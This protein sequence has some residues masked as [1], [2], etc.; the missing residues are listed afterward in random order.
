[1]PG[2]CILSASAQVADYLRGGI[3]AGRW[4]GMMPGGH[5]LAIELGVG[6]N[7]VEAALRQLE[8][9][10]L[11]INQGRRRGR[12]IRP[13]EGGIIRAVLRV[14]LL[15][16][17]V[18]DF[19]DRLVGSLPR[20]L[21]KGG[22]LPLDPGKSM[23]DLKMDPARIARLVRDTAADAWVV[24][25]GSREVLEWFSCQDAPAFA[26]FGRRTGLRIAGAGP[27]NVTPVLNATRHMI[28][29]GHRRIVIIC[30]RERRVPSPGNVERAFLEE[31]AKHGIPSGEYNLPDWQ[32][33]TGAGLRKVLD[34]LFRTTPP[35]AL[36]LDEAQVLA[37]V[38]QFLAQRNIQVPRDVSLFCTFSDPVFDFCVPAMA[39]IRWETKHAARC[40]LRW[41]GRVAEGVNDRRQILFPAEF[42]E[43]G[44]IGPANPRD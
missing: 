17:E 14:A 15:L 7:T 26:F 27:D 24:V 30:R 1:M 43:G 21:E 35:T 39:S 32:E 37:A 36:I 9:E 6:V 34:S 3:L 28:G 38:L 40:L 18:Y 42:V 23:H 44:S 5:G 4:G 13:P 25:G 31:L 22:H 10:G 11:L 20:E 19:N 2:I 33:E 29:L 12:L 16:S 8:A 41:A